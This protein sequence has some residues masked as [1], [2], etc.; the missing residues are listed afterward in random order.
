MSFDGYKRTGPE[1]AIL[2]S[3]DEHWWRIHHRRLE[4]EQCHFSPSKTS[5]AMAVRTV[6]LLPALERAEKDNQSMSIFYTQL[7][8]VIDKPG[9]SQNPKA[10]DFVFFLC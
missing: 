7:A 10:A 8:V 6:L 2:V 1:A 4:F 5:M 3:Y 9:C